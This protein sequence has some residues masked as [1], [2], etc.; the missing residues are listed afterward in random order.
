MNPPPISEIE[1]QYAGVFLVTTSGKIV[2]QMR[3]N[4]PTIDN[5]NQ[6]TS[7][8]GTVEEDE[9]FDAAAWRELVEEETNLKLKPEEIHL[10]FEDVAWRKFTSEWE[11]RH[12]YYATITDAQFD[13]LEVYEGQGWV[14]IESPSDK[15]LVELW[16]IPVQRLI[17]ILK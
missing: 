12:F 13:Q 1:H 15:L 17:D 8:G 11:G 9:D 16:R 4:K 6:V 10:Y 3:D 14:I 5:P 7:F 2:G